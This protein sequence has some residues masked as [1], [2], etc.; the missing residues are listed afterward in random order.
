M[1]R[2][3]EA[4]SAELLVEQILDYQ[5][6]QSIM[7]VTVQKLQVLCYDGNCH[8]TPTY[9]P[10]ACLGCDLE[11]MIVSPESLEVQS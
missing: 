11:N 3:R 5:A 2:S 9:T 4:A 10:R 7:Y 1:W 8:T 6:L